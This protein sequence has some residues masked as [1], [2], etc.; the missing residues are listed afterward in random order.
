[1]HRIVELASQP[2][3]RLQSLIGLGEEFSHRLKSETGVAREHDCH[4]MALLRHGKDRETGLSC[5]TFRRT[6]S[7]PSLCGFDHRIG[8]EVNIRPSDRPQ[9]IIHDN[10]TIHLREFGK[11]LSGVGNIDEIKSP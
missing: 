11:S 3:H 1:V 10:S 5:E 9:G 6:E 7:R 4:E 2:L 8:Y